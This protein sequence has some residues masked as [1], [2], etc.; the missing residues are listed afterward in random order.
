MIDPKIQE[1][2]K[3]VAKGQAEIAIEKLMELIDK[4]NDRAYHVA[5]FNRLTLTSAQYN[6][7]TSDH[8][9]GIINL[10]EL[11]EV[12]NKTC[13]EILSV[14]DLYTDL[15]SDIKNTSVDHKEKE[16]KQN[17]GEFNLSLKR[18]IQGYSYDDLAKLL[19]SIQEQIQN[20][21][22][23]KVISIGKGSV[24]IRLQMTK[25][26]IVKFYLMYYR[27]KL[28]EYLE[29]EIEIFSLISVNL[30]GAKLRGVDLSTTNL[31][32]ANLSE[33]ILSE[34]NLI[35]ANLR[36]ADLQGANLIRANLQGAYLQRANL[37]EAYLQGANLIGANLQ[38]ADLSK[39]NLI[40]AKLKV[41]KLRRTKL[42]RAKLNVT[43]LRGADLTGATLLQSQYDYIIST[44]YEVNLTDVKIIPDD[45]INEIIGTGVEV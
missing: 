10:S 7:A 6:F 31:S 16:K 17:L 9:T 4:I 20:L 19:T 26:D 11:N 22:P 1:I 30:R 33:A 45:T 35:R 32:E 18:E 23:V 3:A 14:C 29:N 5:L 41:T 13:Q 40:G 2:K 34:A 21:N 24:I 28:N 36:G 42:R 39:A 43:N 15:P 27:D 12:R 25:E 44:G 37:I 38:G 8:N